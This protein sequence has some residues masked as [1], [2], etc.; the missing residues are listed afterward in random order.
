MAPPPPRKAQ[1]SQEAFDAA[2]RENVEDFEME[3]G[4]AIAD[5]VHT[6][7]L[8]GVDLT[9][10]IT[11]GRGKEEHPVILAIKDLKLAVDD[12]A[13]MDRLCE[14]L[15][16]LRLA[17]AGENASIAV[18]NG[19]VEKAVL[20]CKRLI[21]ENNASYVSTAM[22][23]LLPLLNDEQSKKDFFSSAGCE[24][25][26]S[27][28]SRHD[29][30]SE[31]SMLSAAVIASSASGSEMLKEEFM[32]LKADEKLIKLLRRYV[33]NA[34]V[35]SSACDALKALVS[36]DDTN[37]LAS[38]AFKNA[39]TIWKAGAV[40][41]V[42]ETASSNRKD[43]TLLVTLCATLKAMAV[44]EEICKSITGDNGLELTLE[45][46]DESAKMPNKLLAKNACSLITQ[47]AL[48]DANK[49]AIVLQGGCQ[50]LVTLASCYSEDVSVIQEVMSAIA[51]IT[52]RSPSN[53]T[54]AVEAG[55]IDLA[56]E[57]MDKHPQAPGMQKQTC[58]MLRNLASRNPENRALILERGL[59][60]LIRAAKS[61]HASCKDA[62]SAALR[63][64][65]LDNYN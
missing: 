47:L 6:F 60:K 29:D 28:L 59:E 35:L 46:V 36:P 43:P 4:E 49:D 45:F 51:S 44:N 38:N 11:D 18:R 26:L 19:A 64:L 15:D 48:S 55:A 62:S 50:K 27:F 3:E 1:I 22:K 31:I 37:V 9:G 32:H 2:V 24:V 53:A 20:A 13:G 33:E 14:A 21:D 57:M 10:I 41:A 7:Q 34:E 23:T 25:I 56:V 39:R 40:N 54:K 52:L 42:L 58:H 61:R 63:D 30:S 65:G 12:N 16:K 5:A 17:S 8:Q